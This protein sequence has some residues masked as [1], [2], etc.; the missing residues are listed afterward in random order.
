MDIEKNLAASESY[1]VD[2]AFLFILLILEKCTQHLVS[3]TWKIFYCHCI[4]FTSALPVA[5]SVWPFISATLIHL[6][7]ES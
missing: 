3:R 6:V 4:H 2:K 5:A 7:A 1:I